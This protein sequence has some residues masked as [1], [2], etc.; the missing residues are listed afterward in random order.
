MLEYLMDRHPESE[1]ADHTDCLILSQYTD[2]R[3]TSP[4]AL[5][6]QA[7]GR[8]ATGVPVFQSLV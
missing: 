6:Y 2:T 1:G 8:V 7:P 4:N 5:Q 3:T